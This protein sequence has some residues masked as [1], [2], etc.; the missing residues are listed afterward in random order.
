[1]N[2]DTTQNDRLHNIVLIII[3]VACLGA[4]IESITQGWEFWV[5]PLMLI[6]LGAGWIIHVTHYGKSALREHYY[7]IFCMLVS[8][9]H[10]IH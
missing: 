3:S 7:L 6:G 8:F 9:F 4:I 2:D 10:G 5:P 1:M